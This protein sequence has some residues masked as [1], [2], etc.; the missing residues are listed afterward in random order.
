[1]HLKGVWYVIQF[2]A[3]QY[4]SQCS[5][6]GNSETDSFIFLATDLQQTVTLC[7]LNSKLRYW[8]P[9]CSFCLPRQASAHY[10][11]LAVE[12][13]GMTERED[14]ERMQEP[15]YS[16][17]FYYFKLAKFPQ[18]VSCILCSEHSLPS[19]SVGIF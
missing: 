19:A 7:L 17:H 5:Q 10:P 11:R 8:V 18:H 6:L 3:E 13:L 15:V 2:N 16:G 1:M 4:K 9:Q 12:E 14:K